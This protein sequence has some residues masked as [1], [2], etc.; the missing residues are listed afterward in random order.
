MAVNMKESCISLEHQF[1]KNVTLVFVNQ[2]LIQ[3]LMAFGDV[4]N[5]IVVMDVLMRAPLIMLSMLLK[6]MALANGWIVMVA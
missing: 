1:S 5:K 6:T 3:M 2:V 4:Q